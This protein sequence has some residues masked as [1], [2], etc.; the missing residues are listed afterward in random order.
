MLGKI[1]VIASKM[2]NL[3]SQCADDRKKK[4][5]KKKRNRKK[6]KEKKEKNDQHF[7]WSHFRNFFLGLID[8]QKQRPSKT[9]PP[10]T[11]PASGGTLWR[12]WERL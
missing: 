9:P 4:K 1:F 6:R 8:E 10:S 11:W 5:K 12:H 7:I 3:S 2:S